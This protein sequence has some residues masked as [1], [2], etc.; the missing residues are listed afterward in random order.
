M[1]S[2]L[3]DY[4]IYQHSG[5]KYERDDCSIALKQC[6]TTSNMEIFLKCAHLNLELDEKFTYFLKRLMSD[7]L[8]PSLRGMMVKFIFGF[9]DS[10]LILYP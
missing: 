8:N 7:G 10:N 9:L 5:A 3:K 6:L 1:I 4:Q 2:K